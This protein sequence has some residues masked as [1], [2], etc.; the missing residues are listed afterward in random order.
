MKR[1]INAN[2]VGLVVIAIG[3][4]LFLDAVDVFNFSQLL[5]DWW[6]MLIVLAGIIS[7]LGNPKS[8]IWPLLFVGVGVVLQMSTLD[9]IDIRVGDLVF[10]FV[11][12]IVGVSLLDSGKVKKRTDSETSEDTVDV[13]AAFAGVELQN[14]SSDFKGGQAQA[15][16]GGV[17]LD[18]SE[19]SIKTEAELDVSAVFGGLEVRVPRE[20]RVEVEVSPVFGGVEDNT[21]Q[22]SKKSSPILRLKG[23][24]L[25]GGVEIKN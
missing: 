22:P 14:A 3:L 16:F 1:F 11:L 18:L 19:A 6:P 13:T 7:F 21:R 24:C 15:V 10:P 2:A 5:S 20:W 25:F 12:L 23:K 9:L 17:A 4:G 8:L